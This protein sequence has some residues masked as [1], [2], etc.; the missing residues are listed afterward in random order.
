MEEEDLNENLELLERE[1]VI[2]IKELESIEFFLEN[3]ERISGKLLNS[4]LN[5]NDKELFLQ[6]KNRI[7]NKR[8][9]IYNRIIQIKKKMERFRRRRMKLFKKIKIKNTMI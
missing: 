4:S 3:L 7:Y 2:L 5:K 8:D 1:R 9:F 6:L